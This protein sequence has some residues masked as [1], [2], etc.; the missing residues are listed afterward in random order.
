MITS[1]YPGQ[2]AF[3]F[4][5]LPVKLLKPLLKC[6]SLSYSDFAGLMI[7]A[8]KLPMN[9]GLTSSGTRN[10]LEHSRVFSFFSLEIVLFDAS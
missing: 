6:L 2:C 5:L 1:T 8:C 9:Y 10:P 4:L 3:S 7:T